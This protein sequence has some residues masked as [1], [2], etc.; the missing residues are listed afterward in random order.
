ME[1]LGHKIDAEGLHTLPGK[2][3]AVMNAP[4]P[5]NIQELCS[6][7][8]LWNYYGKFLPNLSSVVHPLNSVLQKSKQWKW[9]KACAQAFKQAKEALSSASVLAHYDPTLPL[10]LAEDASAYGCHFTCAP[11]WQRKAHCFA[12]RSLSS[13]ER[14]YAQI[15]KEAL[16]LIFGVK[17]F[18][19]YL[20]GRKFL[21]L[22]DHKPLL[23]ILGPKKGIPSLAA[24]CLQR[25]A[26]LLSAYHYEIEF[27]PTDDHGN[28]DGLSRLPLPADADTTTISTKT[29]AV[30]NI[31]QIEALPITSSQI[32]SATKKDKILSKV[33]HYTKSGWPTQV[34]DALTTSSSTT[35]SAD[36]GGRL[37]YVGN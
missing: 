12:S 33:Y 3:E 10:T 9:S 30:F 1:F 23:A 7:L 2:N 22:T 24:A 34:S 20:Y 8:G 36:C 15:E 35:T 37:P 25:W 28:A 14:N 18:H 29:T 32:G 11:G 26:V 5:R 4:E 16:S 17:K 31:S 27:K 21:L 19:Q 13:S 6:F